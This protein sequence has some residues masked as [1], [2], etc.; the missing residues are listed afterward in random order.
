MANHSLGCHA[1]VDAGCDFD[2]LSD[3]TF[4]PFGVDSSTLH[5]PNAFHRIFVEVDDSNLEMNA[6]KALERA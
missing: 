6:P 1:L 2:D 5:R 4:H 3:E